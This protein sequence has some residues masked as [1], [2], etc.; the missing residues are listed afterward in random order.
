MNDTYWKN[1]ASVN[2]LDINELSLLS[3]A[4]CCVSGRGR[5]KTKEFNSYTLNLH[6]LFYRTQLEM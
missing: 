2:T 6:I 5:F 4:A 3:S 1:S